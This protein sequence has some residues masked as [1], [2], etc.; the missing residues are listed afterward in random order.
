MI[1]LVNLHYVV[2]SE[3]PYRQQAEE[4][5]A[6]EQVVVDHQWYPSLRL[7]SV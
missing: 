5:F 2:I 6:Q 1:Q 4:H 3:A 7:A